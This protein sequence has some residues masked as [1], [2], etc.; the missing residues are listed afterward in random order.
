MSYTFGFGNIFEGAKNV[1]NTPV[2][3][4]PKHVHQALDL[5]YKVV[6]LAALILP[7]EILPPVTL[8]AMMVL[9]IAKDTI[10]YTIQTLSE[11]LSWTTVAK[12]TA[13]NALQIASVAIEN[14]LLEKSV[15]SKSKSQS[16][17]SSLESNGPYCTKG[18]ETEK[19]FKDLKKCLQKNPIADCMQYNHPI[20]QSITLTLPCR[21]GSQP[22]IHF[23]SDGSVVALRVESTIHFVTKGSIHK[24]FTQAT[25]AIGFENEPRT[26]SCIRDLK[27]QV[28][29]H[30]KST[31]ESCVF[32]QLIEAN[33]K[34]GSKPACVIT[35]APLP[36]EQFITC[37]E[38]K[39]EEFSLTDGAVQYPLPSQF[40][41]VFKETTKSLQGKKFVNK[42]STSF[43]IENPCKHGFLP[44]SQCENVHSG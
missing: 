41:P 35:A 18:S 44:K 32:T 21:G 37:L 8:P 17:N 12:C 25:N 11:N 14:V 43:V 15:T 7:K 22:A 42:E 4:T 9:G 34:V 2:P 19:V 16:D 26:I 24:G 23:E 33:P 6:T 1:W 29:T 5:G 10:P 20:T 40:K 30:T 38:K 27:I 3:F 13:F 31:K 36:E 28:V 39:P